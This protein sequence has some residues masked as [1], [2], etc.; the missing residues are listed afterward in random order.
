MAHLNALG[1]EVRLGTVQRRR[2]LD[3]ERAPARCGPRNPS[4]VRLVALG[5]VTM[6]PH[7]SARTGQPTIDR[8][9]TITD[10]GRRYLSEGRDR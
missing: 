3:C 2:L 5:F 6:A 4:F 1:K 7:R 10:E 9:Y 8:L